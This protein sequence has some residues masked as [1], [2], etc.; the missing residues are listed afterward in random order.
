MMM[1]MMMIMTTIMIIT[2]TY[3]SFL[4]NIDV[5]REINI[6]NFYCHYIIIINIKHKMVIILNFQK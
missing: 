6:I 1:M 4:I 5:I 2:T 3:Y